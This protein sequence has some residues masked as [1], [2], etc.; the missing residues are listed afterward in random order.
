MDPKKKTATPSS[1]ILAG[2]LA[3]GTNMAWLIVCLLGYAIAE[4]WLSNMDRAAA[5]VLLPSP[6]LLSWFEFFMQPIATIGTQHA[7][8]YLDALRYDMSTI[9]LSIAIIS[10]LSF[11]LGVWCF[12]HQ[13]RYAKHGAISWAI[14]VFA[15][16][17]PGLIGYLLYRRWP[18]T[19]KCQHC[20]HI[21]PRDRDACLN[22][23]AEF[24]LPPL[25]GIE[26]FA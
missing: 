12:F 21:T 8:N 24:P 19:E 5:P 1:F 26:I 20:G 6:L 15:M 3:C 7:T 13:R 4:P 23:G 16:G 14:F 11:P 10:W 25:K 17:L 22:C 18:V 2:I 9:V